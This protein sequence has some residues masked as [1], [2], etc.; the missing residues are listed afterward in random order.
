MA[1]NNTQEKRTTMTISILESD[2]VLLQKHAID[3]KKTS[4]A[5]IHEWIQVF[6][7]ERKEDEADVQE[8]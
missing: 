1:K 5:L 7:G 6:C 8:I 3:V 2:K 4:S